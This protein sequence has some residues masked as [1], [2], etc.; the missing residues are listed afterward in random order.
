MTWFICTYECSVCIYFCAPHTSWAYGGCRIP[1]NGRYTQL[2][3]YLWVLGTELGSPGRVECAFNDWGFSPAPTLTFK[4]NRQFEKILLLLSKFTA[5]N[6]DLFLHCLLSSETLACLH[7]PSLSKAVYTHP[8]ET[9]VPLLNSL[10]NWCS[11]LRSE[12]ECWCR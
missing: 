4:G 1:C 12:M 9:V 6:C 3:A 8:C 7:L 2:W 5:T 11:A 10:K